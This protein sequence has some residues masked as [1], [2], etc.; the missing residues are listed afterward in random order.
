MAFSL[1]WWLLFVYICIY[2]FLEYVVGFLSG[3]G[4][5]F[6]LFSNKVGMVNVVLFDFLSRFVFLFL[7]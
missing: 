4:F 5:W 7:M 2:L 3:F 1:F 6:V